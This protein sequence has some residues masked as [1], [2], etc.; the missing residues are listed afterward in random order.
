M[1]TALNISLSERN[2][3]L[4]KKQCSFSFHKT[5]YRWF[6]VCYSVS[7]LFVV[8]CIDKAWLLL[9][10]FHNRGENTIDC[11]L[12]GP[13]RSYRSGKVSLNT[14]S[15]SVD[16][17]SRFPIQEGDLIGYHHRYY[18]YNGTCLWRSSQGLNC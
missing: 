12:Q 10:W 9:A 14:R 5:D 13:A 15:G 16:G 11:H 2:L 7:S 4:L 1:L 18:C 6:V 8:T 3:L 17:N